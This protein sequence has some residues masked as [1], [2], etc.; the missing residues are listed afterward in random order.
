MYIY[1]HKLNK[2]YED[3]YFE[4]SKQ[5]YDTVAYMNL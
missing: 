2:N 4:I 1:K 3:N 5:I